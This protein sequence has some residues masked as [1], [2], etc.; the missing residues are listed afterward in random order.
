M[1]QECLDNAVASAAFSLIQRYQ[2]LRLTPQAS[3]VHQNLLSWIRAQPAR[4][5]H[6]PEWF[7]WNGRFQLQT[8]RPFPALA[9]LCRSFI[10]NPSLIKRTL[11]APRALCR[12]PTPANPP[13]SQP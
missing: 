13:L 5:T 10:G 9:S 2:N 3:D 1:T 6:L 11:L 8:A 12:R 4:Q 7:W